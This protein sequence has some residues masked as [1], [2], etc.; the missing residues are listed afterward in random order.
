VNETIQQIPLDQLTPCPTN[1]RIGGFDKIKLAQL[2]DSIKSVGVQQPAVVRKTAEQEYE[3]VSGERRWRASELVKMPALPCIVRILTDEQVIKIRAIENIQRDD[4]H[5]L[6]EADSYQQLLNVCGYEVETIAGE[7]G[8]SISYVY[9]RL[10]LRDLVPKARDYLVEGMITVGHAILIARLEPARQAEVLKDGLRRFGDQIVSVH[11]LDDFIR[12]S[13]LLQLSS[14]TWKLSDDQLLPAAGACS[15]CPKRTGAAPAL[16]E[17]IGKKDHCLDRACFIKKA[18]ASVTAKRKEL[19]DEPHLEVRGGY[20]GPAVEGALEAHD[21]RECKKSDPGAVRVL[22]V[23]GDNAGKLTYGKAMGKT[24]ASKAATLD[25]KVVAKEKAERAKEKKIK[26][27]RESLLMDIFHAIYEKSEKGIKA[28][29]EGDD[30]LGFRRLMA[31]EIWGGLG[32]DSWNWIAKIENWP[33]PNPT[34]GSNSINWAPH[35]EELISS[36]DPKALDLFLV[37]CTFGPLSKTST[38]NYFMI[39]E[40]FKEAAK[41][42]DLDIK[43]MISRKLVETELKEKELLP[44]VPKYLE[45]LDA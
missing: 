23:D 26:D 17:D 42:F 3:I 37:L 38:S 11:A 24:A 7:L 16:F 18:K 10:K 19:E 27:A 33:K 28:R 4:V 35:A 25:P 30:V 41:L 6:D 43:A 14:A 29:K 32:W 2:A 45:E 22:V 15:K 12:R 8:K 9:Q 1:R 34:K 20:G 44:P 36:M 5:P 39:P 21:W 31:I 40:R 13:I